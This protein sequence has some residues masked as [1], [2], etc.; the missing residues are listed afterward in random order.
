[1]AGTHTETVFDKLTKPELFQLL[2]NTGDNTGAPISTLTAEI[3]DL[4]N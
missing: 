3:K 4:N 2:F 1:M